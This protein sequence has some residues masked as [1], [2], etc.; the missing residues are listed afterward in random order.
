[1]NTSETRQWAARAINDAYSRN[2]S[3]KGIEAMKRTAAMAETMLGYYRD[4][5]DE[6][7]KIDLDYDELTEGLNINRQQKKKVHD[8]M[9][10]IHKK[11]LSNFIEFEKIM[12]QFI[13][14]TYRI[15]EK[16]QDELHCLDEQI[17]NEQELKEE[18]IRLVFK[19]GKRMVNVNQVLKKLNVAA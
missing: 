9:L 5:R 13:Q 16:E 8:I 14:M 15:G 18:L 7:S 3:D 1:M 19:E 17:H 10:P 2:L 12:E 11:L 6:V 4:Y